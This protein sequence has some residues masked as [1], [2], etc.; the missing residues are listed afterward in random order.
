M[1]VMSPTVQGRPVAA[2]GLLLAREEGASCPCNGEGGG[3]KD[4]L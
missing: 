2:N 1:Q 4:R 3:M